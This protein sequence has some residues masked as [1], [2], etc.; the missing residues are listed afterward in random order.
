MDSRIER[1]DALLDEVEALDP[2]ARDTATELVQALLELQGEGLARIAA[3]CPELPVDD[4]LVAHLLLLHG[5]HPVP[6]AQRVRGALD[7][8]RPYLRQHGGGVELLAIDKGVVRLRLEGSC[9]GCPSSAVTLKL[10]V[11]EAIQR[12]A[13]DVERIEAEGAAAPSGLLQIE[14]ACPVPQG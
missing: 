4:E 12:A 10:A 8:V 14:I 5:L 7:E 1:I 6:L 3:R 2:G 9:N 13:P 11:E